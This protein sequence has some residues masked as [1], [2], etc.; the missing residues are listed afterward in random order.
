MVVH[1][2]I[3]YGQV[4]VRLFAGFNTDS[5]IFTVIR[6]EY[7]IDYFPDGTG[8]LRK[9]QEGTI[10]KSGDKLII[11]TT[12]N[13][14]WTVSDSVSFT[15]TNGNDSFS[16]STSRLK[17]KTR[18]YSGDLYCKPDL[19]TNLLINT[20][21]I[22]SYIAGVVK[23][24]GG[25][26]RHP[27]YF[28]TQAVIARTYMQRHMHKHALDGFNLCD[29]IHCQAFNGITDD[30]LIINAALST[31]GL[32]IT[33]TDLQP[34]LAVFHSNYGGETLEPEN[35]WL[36]GQPYLKKVKDPYCTSSPNSKWRRTISAG[37]WIGYLKR[38]GMQSVPSGLSS[39]NF[40]QPVRLVNYR[41]GNFS[42]P[43]TQ[44]REDLGLRSSFFSVKVEGDS[45]IFSG[46]GY[47]HGVGLCQ[48]GAMVMA[49]RGFDFRKIIGFYYKGV[50]VSDIGIANS[51]TR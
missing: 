45:I 50:I 1:T 10:I 30:S 44:I 47:G 26:G 38:S 28:K 43:F 12:N 18:F 3:L 5:V 9:G 33:G 25:S 27:E 2:A 6:G 49:S 13:P 31:S 37:D 29:D 22:E 19:G 51:V 11:K 42:I 48:E 36:R 8:L 39:M 17:Q 20:C 46:R 35:L 15:G 14:F 32:I 16:I 41:T 40:N 21:D 23:S 34:I 4:K 7:E 24:E